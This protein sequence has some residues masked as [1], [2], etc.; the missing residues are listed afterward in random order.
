MR[1]LLATF[2]L[3]SALLLSGCATVGSP[4]RT[5]IVADELL[6]CKNAPPVPADTSK[7]KAVAGYIVDLHGAY[8]DCKSKLGSVAKV[9]KP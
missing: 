6:K 1:A 7:S 5:Q 8:A 3:T 4:S 2:L 9:V